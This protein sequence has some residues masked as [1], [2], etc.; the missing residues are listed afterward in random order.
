M[1]KDWIKAEKILK[2]DSLF[3]Q[4]G[5]VIL[6][7]DTLYGL[8]TSVF[9]KKEVERIYDI[10]GRNNE[11]PFIVLINSYKQLEIFGIKLNNEQKKFLD[12]NWP[13]KISVILECKNK[14]WQYLHRGKDSIAFRMIGQKNKNL[15][16]LIEKVG[17]VISS[18]VNL[19]DEKPAETITEAKNYF[20]NKINLYINSGIKKSLPSTLVK[21]KNNQVIILRQGDKKIDNEK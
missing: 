5:V 21:F 8:V 2:K 4:V 19:E 17:P 3:G 14:K 1:L 18:S 10:K 12:K 7:T 13:G 20:G 11:K 9:S 15:F 6:P 16:N